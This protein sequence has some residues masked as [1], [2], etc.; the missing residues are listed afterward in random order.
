MSTGAIFSK[1]FSESLLSLYP[2]FVKNIDLSLPLQLL[3]RVS[4][5]VLVSLVF[6]QMGFIHKHLFSQMGI[7]LGMT[8]LI[9]IYSSYRGFQLLESGISYTLF[10]T[11]PIIIL[12]LS[13]QPFHWSIL[14][15]LLGVYLLTME[16]LKEVKPEREAFENE[17]HKENYG[18]EGFWMIFL[19]AFTEAIIYF[20]V[21]N[22]KTDNNWN[23]VFISYFFGAIVMLFYVLFYQ[24]IP[25]QQILQ[26]KQFT[27]AIFIN[28]II[29]TLGY[30]F[31][32][33]AA[34]RM[35]PILYA[36]LSYFGIFMSFV[37]GV[38][39]NKDVITWKKILGV[40]LIVF[41][42]FYIILQKY[43]VA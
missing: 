11:Y 33:Y 8:T 17:E 19:A 29:G 26:Q 12:L 39:F 23:H 14:V 36:F 6:C 2:V 40:L 38:I 30:Y 22:I 18:Y 13:G 32:F 43:K 15:S 34:T 3:S 16:Q 41:S 37:Y 31:R 21:R 25:I 9:H 20:Q 5:Y 1:I 28:A 10:Y 42:N 24:Q 35:G 4:I 7:L 27:I